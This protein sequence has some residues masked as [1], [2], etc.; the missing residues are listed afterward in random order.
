MAAAAAWRG[1]VRV[2]ESRESVPLGTGG[3][4]RLAT[5]GLEAWPVLVLN[6]D[7]Y[8]EVDLA[9]FA[10]FH[11]DRAAVASLVLAR[12]DD[13]GRFGAVECGDDGAVRAFREK[14][15]GAGPGWINAGVYL[16]GPTV[17]AGIA[18]GSAASL[19]REVFPALVASGL[20][21]YPGGGRFLDIGVPESY[22]AAERFL[23]AGAAR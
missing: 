16:L 7:S 11:R 10:A 12:V 2:T 14:A 13:A 23:A 22:A 21:G 18:P 20:C 8:V 9:A 15:P 1:P 19:E 3:A 4:V 5:G 6:G 17:L